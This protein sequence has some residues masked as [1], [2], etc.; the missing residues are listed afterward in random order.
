ME[1]LFLVFIG[2]AAKRAGPTDLRKAGRKVPERVHETK[3]NRSSK[4]NSTVD[5]AILGRD[6]PPI[7]AWIRTTR[8]MSVQW[9]IYLI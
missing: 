5:P 1:L 7:M 4:R 8:G 6:I 9:M 2:M 3:I